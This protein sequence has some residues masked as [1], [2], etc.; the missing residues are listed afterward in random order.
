MVM[1]SEGSIMP[2]I[3]D[4][5]YREYCRA[6]LVEM[7][8]ALLIPVNSDEILQEPRGDDDPS[9]PRDRPDGCAAKEIPATG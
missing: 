9:G 1:I 7:R 5:L 8:K 4:M 6:R 2:T 3:L